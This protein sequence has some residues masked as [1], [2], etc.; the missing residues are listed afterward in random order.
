MIS[1]RAI[2]IQLDMISLRDIQMQL[3]MALRDIQILE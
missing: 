2:Q 1:L 3:D